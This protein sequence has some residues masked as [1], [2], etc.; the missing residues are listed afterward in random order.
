MRNPY[1]A[2]WLCLT[3]A[4]CLA[5]IEDVGSAEGSV[6]EGSLHPQ[7]FV[8]I[9]EE[10]ADGS[11]R[12][13]ILSRFDIVDRRAR[14]HVRFNQSKMDSALGDKQELQKRLDDFCG[15]EKPQD[16]EQIFLESKGFEISVVARVLP[17]TGKAFA[18]S[19][20]GY[21]SVRDTETDSTKTTRSVVTSMERRPYRYE[22]KS[23]DRSCYDVVLINDIEDTVIPLPHDHLAKG[24]RV[25]IEV[26]NHAG[27]L[28]KSYTWELEVMDIGLS[29]RTDPTLLLIKRPEVPENDDNE[30]RSDFKPAPGSSLVFGWVTRNRIL[31]KLD[32]RFGLNGSFVD[33]QKDKEF[34]VG[35]GFV[36]SVRGGLLQV[37]YGWNLHAKEKR[38]YWGLG[39]EFLNITE[40]IKELAK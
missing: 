10:K 8:T 15:K 14:I 31:N 20:E 40:K 25:E 30:L 33:F 18:I 22:P 37:V 39:L 13:S 12:D 17:V 27:R 5:T 1:I 24:D 36:L 28:P 21:T 3:L 38:E 4:F 32:L 19:V 35:V 11:L 7:A 6:Q 2:F 26:V 34:E 23:N 16:V 29:L 9:Q